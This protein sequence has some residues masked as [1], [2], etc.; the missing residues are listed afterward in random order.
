MEPSGGWEHWG[1]ALF[2]ECSPNPYLNVPKANAKAKEAEV[3]AKPL[4]LLAWLCICTTGRGI[5][6]SLQSTPEPLMPSVTLQ[7]GVRQSE[8]SSQPRVP[9]LWR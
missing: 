1:Q 4:S 5:K 8:P 7:P 3:G 9:F 6:A 2:P